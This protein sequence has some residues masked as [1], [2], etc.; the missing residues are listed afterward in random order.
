M[1]CWKIKPNCGQNLKAWREDPNVIH[2]PFFDGDV[3]KDLPGAPVGDD[4]TEIRVHRKDEMESYVVEISDLE[5]NAEQE[6][7]G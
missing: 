3:L 7:C 6:P 2:Y 1:N 4:E 5:E